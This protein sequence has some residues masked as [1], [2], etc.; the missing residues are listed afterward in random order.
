MERRRLTRKELVQHI[1]ETMPGDY[2]EY[3]KLAFIEVE[4]AQNIAFDEK[5]LWGE[6]GT[7]EKIYKLAKRQAQN[8]KPE[9]KRKLICIT[10]AELFGYVAKQFGFEAKYQRRIDGEQIEIGENEVFRNISEEQQEHVCTVI[11]LSSGELIEVDV[12]YDLERL[13]TRSKPRA[14]GQRKHDEKG[15]GIEILPIQLVEQTFKKVYGLN[16]DEWFTDEYIMVLSTRL[17][18]QGKS[19]IDVIDSFMNEPRIKAELQNARCIEANKIYRDI[20]RVCYDITIDKQ[21]FQ[22]ENRAIIEECILSD[23]Q[24][25]KKYS[26]CIYAEERDKKVFYIYSK[27]SKRMVRL[28]QEE[29]QQLTRQVM[30]IELKGQPTELKQQLIDFVNGKKENAESEKED[31]ENIS[32]EDIF[33]D[34]DE[35]ELE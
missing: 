5:Y 22:G 32:L 23:E 31:R 13:Q 33:L 7:S 29:I 10:M 30:N 14:F 26:F 12:Q 27:K 34:E 19:L 20:L 17:R 9:I 8:P 18:C 6:V 21:F 35:E 11:G 3:E 15:Q 4:V 16:E 1:R 2:N 25:R 24:G 28:N